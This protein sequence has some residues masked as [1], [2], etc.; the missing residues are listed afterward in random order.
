MHPSCTRVSCASGRGEGWGWRNAWEDRKLRAAS[1]LD[2]HMAGV[3]VRVSAGIR[4]GAWPLK[5]LTRWVA[6]NIDPG[7]VSKHEAVL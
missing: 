3:R 4:V 7:E 6:E 1:K 2:I 5:G